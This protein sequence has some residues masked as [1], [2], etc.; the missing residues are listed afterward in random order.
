MVELLAGRHIVDGDHAAM[1]GTILDAARRPT[2]RVE[3]VRV[4]DAVEAVFQRALALDPRDR[5]RDAGAF[6]NALLTAYDADTERRHSDPRMVVGSNRP[7]SGA[8]LARA[9]AQIPDLDIGSPS[10]SGHYAAQG[11]TSQSGRFPATAPV[12]LDL[13]RA[14]SPEDSESG[15][16]LELDSSPF[17]PSEAEIPTA[18]SDPKGLSPSSAPPSARSVS[19]V[20]APADVAPPGPPP[21]PMV[22]R[23]SMPSRFSDFGDDPASINQLIKRFGPPAIMVVLGVVITLVD[24]AYASAHGEV[25]T[26]GPLRLAWVAASLVLAGI[27]LTLYRFLERPD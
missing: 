18:P 12:A 20:P 17:M 19:S 21:A 9:H 3:G 1:M 2:P 5:F 7:P 15:S 10:R 27:G 13:P 14:S 22:P 24:G 11:A 4:G 16:G 26:L 25:F 6:W 8:S 23:T